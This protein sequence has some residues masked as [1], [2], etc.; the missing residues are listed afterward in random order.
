MHRVRKK[1]NLLGK[2]SCNL[3]EAKYVKAPEFNFHGCLLLYYLPFWRPCSARPM[4]VKAA[5]AQ[6]SL[7]GGRKKPFFNCQRARMALQHYCPPYRYGY[8]NRVDV[9]I[10][11]G[12][13]TLGVFCSLGSLYF[14]IRL[15]MEKDHG[16][17][18]AAAQS[19]LIWWKE[20]GS[21][22]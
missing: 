14:Q 16:K 12:F 9:P 18:A 1:L 19:V 5:D 4:G 13:T 20:V 3:T 11:S 7:A 22:E 17:E 2:N 21:W 8:K 15:K 6:S 10:S